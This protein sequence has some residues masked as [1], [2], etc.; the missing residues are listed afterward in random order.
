[1]LTR[2]ATLKLLGAAAAAPVASA[3]PAASQSPIAVRIAAIGS[4]GQDEVPFAIQKYGLD[5]KHGLAM[6]LVDFAV[7]GQQYTML[8]SDAIDVAAGNFIDLLRQR[9]AGNKIAAFHSFQ[10]YSNLIVTKPQSPI[11]TFA[12]LRGKK[13][14][15]FGTAFLDWL[16]IRAAGQ[17]AYNLDLEKEASPIQ[18]APPLL[19]QFLS[20]GDVDA[21]LQF[22]T[23]TFGPVAA[24]QQ[25]AVSLMPDLM[26]AAGFD[27]GSFYLHWHVSEKWT[28]ANPG[29]LARLDAMIEEA[30]E[31]LRTDDS[32][33][34]P[35]AQKVFITAP[36]LINVYRDEA[37]RIDD[38][39]YTRALIASTQ[40][41]LDG[42]IATTGPDAVGVTQIEPAAFLFPGHA[43]K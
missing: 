37:R 22:S 32:L 42:I 13:V 14:G 1:M 31:K 29:A 5:K 21:T 40:K 36:A 9:K 10:T 11:K 23:L 27:P 30:Y 6:Q 12:D 8:R 33:W 2:S 19:N 25:R 18:G 39:P 38:P 41:L 43:R 28:A 4:G 26:K 17:R 35:L 34:P 16:I 24:G 3:A 15:E 20:R 7:P